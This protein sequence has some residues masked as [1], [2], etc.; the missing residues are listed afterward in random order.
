LK[1]AMLAMLRDLV[2]DPKPDVLDS[3]VLIVQPF[4]NADGNEQLG[5]NNRR[6]QNGPALAG[7]RR[8]AADI[9]L[10]RDYVGADAPETQAS[11]A[12]LN[13]WDPNLFMDLHTTDGSIHGY[14]LTYAPSL[15]PTA[16]TVAPYMFDT[17]MPEIQRRVL[18]HQGFYVHDYGDFSR[19][20]PAN[21][22]PGGGRGFGR[23]GISLEAMI[24][25]S[26]P[27]GWSFRTYD[28]LP[29]YGINYYGLRGRLSIL[30]E[31]F[32][33]DPFPRRVASTYAFVSE[34][35][36]YIGE[37]R[38]EIIALGERADSSVAAWANSPGSS[39]PLALTARMDTTRIEDVRVEEVVALTDS[40]KAEVG[41]GNRQRTGII[42]LV[43][44][45]VMAS[46]T[47]TL[48]RTLP[49]A[50]AFD[51]AAADSLRP[52]LAIHGVHVE[53]LTAPATV[54]AQGFAID[55][56]IDGGQRETPR[57]LKSLTGTWNAPASRTL[58]AGTFIVRAGQPYGLLAFYL[59][60]AES[61]DG[62][63]SYLGGV[64][65]AGREYPVIRVTER[66]T[67]T[68]GPVR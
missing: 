44:M 27:S 18:D 38:R 31:T 39:P 30:S 21:P 4:Y 7:T 46:F 52:I 63:M 51:A 64:M 37:N 17:M 57:N 67:L 9:N 12:M 25:D 3:I 34:I 16:V 58:P 42:Q 47:P 62:L 13:R 11:L 60:E 2:F 1:E 53:E 6:S 61:A 41:M 15:T 29:C 36:S 5:P 8:T 24:A 55:S 66:G 33:H 22:E 50:Y 45:P 20:R 10:N 59:L 49:F 26:I 14:A 48:T 23:G 35:L 40:S 43:R 54:T 68:T 56:I 65:A 19:P 28:Y 32:S